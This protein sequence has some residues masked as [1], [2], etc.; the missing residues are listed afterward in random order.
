MT[1]SGAA[2]LGAGGGAGRALAAEAAAAGAGTDQVSVRVE[3]GSE[4]DDNVHRAERI[5]GAPSPN[6]VASTL[7]RGVLGLST[8]GRIA[9]RQ[10][11][12]VSLLGAGKAFA[13]PDARDENVA[14]VESAL[15]W[16]MLL[17]DRY[18]LSAAGSYYEAIQAG[19]RAERALSGDARDF[20]SLTPVLRAGR[21]TGG[22]GFVEASFGYRWFVYKP[23]RAY[24]FGGPVAALEYR[25]LRESADGSADW[26]VSAGS[27]AELRRFVGARL[28]RS[29][30]GCAE[31]SCTPTPDPSGAR[32]DDQFVSSHL[33]LTYT[34]GLLLG[35]GYT[36]QWNRS[37]SYT[38]SLYRHI[39]AIRIATAMPWRVYLAGRAEFVYARY[40]D[41]VVL[42]TG[43]TGSA[44]ASIDDENRNQM[45]VELSRALPHGL[46]IVA[47]Y[48]LYLNALGQSTV[49]YRRQT[50]TV[51]LTCSLTPQR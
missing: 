18:Q 10:D 39:V 8:A 22:G 9:P 14:V 32:H 33:D 3:A 44:S 17:A 47:R 46:R 41:H 50:M 36:L 15:I 5:Q 29:P 43:P 27:G 40:P 21:L 30:S 25:L 7:A 34:G 13:N 49:E 42:A 4:Y 6:L 45:R 38:E 31:A 35:A 26:E 20:R 1:L 16:K 12:F 11:V 24:D 2:N 51:S 19:T 28:V 37:N 48:S 23:L